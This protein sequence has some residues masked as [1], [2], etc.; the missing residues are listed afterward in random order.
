[1]TYENDNPKLNFIKMPDL[2]SEVLEVANKIKRVYPNMVVLKDISHYKN[3][4]F[5]ELIYGIGICETLVFTDTVMVEC[6]YQQD[7]GFWKM[8]SNWKRTIK[9][10]YDS[11]WEEI[12]KL[13]LIKLEE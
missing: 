9:E 2:P 6:D 12:Q 8:R 13:M 10:A 7:R 11:A 5:Y 4:H 1:M 3:H